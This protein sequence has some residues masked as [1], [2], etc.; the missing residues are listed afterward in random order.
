IEISVRILSCCLTL[1]ILIKQQDNILTD[2][3]IASGAITPISTRFYEIE[4]K[5]INNSINDSLIISIVT[6]IAKEI[7]NIT[8]IRWSYPYKLPVFQQLL[9]NEIKKLTI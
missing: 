5:Y 2:I 1:A 9:F 4:N 3:S 6:E 7:L 8:G